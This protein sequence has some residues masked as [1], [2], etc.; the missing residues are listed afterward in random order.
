MNRDSFGWKECIYL[1]RDKRKLVGFESKIMTLS[2]SH[3]LE[4][5]NFEG[6]YF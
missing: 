3:S 1:A 5:Y 4:I 6:E 2:Q